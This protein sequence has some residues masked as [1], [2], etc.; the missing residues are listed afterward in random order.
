MVFRCFQGFEKGC[1]RNK[2][3]KSNFLSN[4]VVPEKDFMKTSIGLTLE[5]KKRFGFLMLS[6]RSK[7]N[8]GKKGVQ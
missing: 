8:I 1:I 6:G 4:C 3:I 2:W 5:I 7:G